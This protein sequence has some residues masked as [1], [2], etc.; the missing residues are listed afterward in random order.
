MKSYAD[1]LRYLRAHRRC[2]CDSVSGLPASVMSLT[3]IWL[4]LAIAVERL[5]G[6]APRGRALRPVTAPRQDLKEPDQL[7]GVENRARWYIESTNQDGGLQH[8]CSF[9]EF[10]ERGD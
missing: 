7:Q 9:V 3:V 8:S 2:R 6:H 1:L 5:A 4:A 10:D